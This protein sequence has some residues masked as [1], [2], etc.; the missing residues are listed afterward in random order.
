MSDQARY[1]RQT[2]L[3]GALALVGLVGILD[4]LTHQRFTWDNAGAAV[5]FMIFVP[6]T[7]RAVR[8]QIRAVRSPRVIGMPGATTSENHL[9]QGQERHRG[10]RSMG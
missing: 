6:L 1:R 3:Y 7:V 8:L 2:S 4:M 9:G 10:H 5:L